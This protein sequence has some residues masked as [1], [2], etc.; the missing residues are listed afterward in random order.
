MVL[1]CGSPQWTTAYQT[2]MTCLMLGL[3]ATPCRSVGN[4]AYTQVR[5][6]D[7]DT[8]SPSLCTIRPAWSSLGCPASITLLV[9]MLVVPLLLRM[10][11]AVW[12]YLLVI[13]TIN[14]SITLRSNLTSHSCSGYRGHTRKVWHP[15]FYGVISTFFMKGCYGW[16][17]LLHVRCKFWVLNWFLKISVLVRGCVSERCIVFHVS[18]CFLLYLWSL[19]MAPPWSMNQCC[20]GF[21]N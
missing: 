12:R 20:L 19:V 11:F 18:N 2:C 9:C 3:E 6:P 13:S 1:C 5:G 16:V 17:K 14:P 21:S 8:V 4:T 10:T 7:M 15:Y